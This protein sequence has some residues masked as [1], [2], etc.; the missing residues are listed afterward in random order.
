M[1]Y[2]LWEI[3]LALTTPIVFIVIAWRLPNILSVIKD[4]K[5]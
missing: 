3:M 1:Q 2:G 5:K 4:W